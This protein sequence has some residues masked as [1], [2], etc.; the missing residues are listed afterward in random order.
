MSFHNNDTSPSSALQIVSMI[1]VTG[2]CQEVTLIVTTTSMLST[3]GK[4]DIVSADCCHYLALHVSPTFRGHFRSCHLMQSRGTEIK[5]DVT[6]SHPYRNIIKHGE[7]SRVSTFSM[8]CVSVAE[9]IYD[10]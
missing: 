4:H 6:K 7:H 1:A 5:P 9:Y 2:D 10:H 8:M 3:A